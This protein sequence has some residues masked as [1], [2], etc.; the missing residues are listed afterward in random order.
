M[1]KEK[2][3]KR[4]KS[5]IY[6]I[7]IKQNEVGS[8]EIQPHSRKFSSKVN[9]FLLFIVYFMLFFSGVGKRYMF[10]G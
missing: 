5:S 6:I 8:Y 10:M 3:K 1:T 9:I 7:A 2:K 4:K